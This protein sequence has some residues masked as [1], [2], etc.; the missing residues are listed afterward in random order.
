MIALSDIA[1]KNKVNSGA[2]LDIVV[3]SKD[4]VVASKVESVVILGSKAKWEVDTI[5]LSDIAA[6][7]MVE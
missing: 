5:L 3:A 7:N 6:A 1:A 4:I 2:E